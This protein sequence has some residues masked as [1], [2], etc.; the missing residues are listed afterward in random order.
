MSFRELVDDL[1]R[2]DSEPP[3]MVHGRNPLVNHLGLD[4][5]VR[6]QTPLR[7]ASRL[8]VEKCTSNRRGIKQR[9]FVFK[10]FY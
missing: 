6:F 7:S 8:F 1:A 10:K 4:N 3:H 5:S 2:Q 9:F